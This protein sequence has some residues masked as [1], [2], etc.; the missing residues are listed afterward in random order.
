MK[1][2]I[3]LLIAI[4]VACT[5]LPN[6]TAS[7]Q[8]TV[9]DREGNPLPGVTVTAGTQTVS[10]DGKGQYEFEN[11]PTGKYV[12]IAKLEA[13]NEGRLRISVNGKPV[14]HDIAIS[15]SVSESITVTAEAPTSFL[16]GVVGGIIGARAKPA[17][18]ALPASVPMQVEPQ[19]TAQYAKIKENGFVDTRKEKT[20]TFSIDVDGAS[21]ANVRRFL[22]ANLVPPSD[23]VRVEEMINYFTYNYPQPTDSRPLT[24]ATEVA[25]CP[26]DAN[27]RLLRIGIQGK[28]IDQWKLAPNN[29]VFLLDVSGSMQPPE[30]LPL[31]TSAFR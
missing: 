12:V 7:L 14:R 4:V 3:V 10:T 15:S 9:V 19:S 20:T 25:G 26:W 30:R 2:A 18:V 31:L 28:T 29:L 5:S 6:K 22:N 11:L 21:Y 27:H 17:A 16:G 13:F 1:R 23:A 24:V 8:G